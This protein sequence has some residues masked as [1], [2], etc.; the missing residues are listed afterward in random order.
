MW[1]EEWFESHKKAKLQYLKLQYV[2]GTWVPVV[3]PAPPPTYTLST[4]VR[5]WCRFQLCKYTFGNHH[6]LF[7]FKLELS[8]LFAIFSLVGNCGNLSLP[9]LLHFDHWEQFDHLDR[10]VLAHSQTAPLQPA[11]PTGRPFHSRVF[12]ALQQ[13]LVQVGVCGI[14]ETGLNISLSTAYLL[15]QVPVY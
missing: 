10:R 8:L 7:W 6:A 9:C 13:S 1:T 2:N 12:Q 3:P 5:T 11:P 14:V 4:K 15:T